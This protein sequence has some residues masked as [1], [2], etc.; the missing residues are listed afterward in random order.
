[1]GGREWER[2]ERGERE[3]VVHWHIVKGRSKHRKKCRT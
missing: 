1:M 2:L 3:R